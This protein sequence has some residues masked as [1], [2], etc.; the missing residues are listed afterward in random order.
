ML[1]W[2]IQLR[3][4]YRLFI[5]I[6]GFHWNAMKCIYLL[7]HLWI[8]MLVWP[9]EKAKRKELRWT[10]PSK[11]EP[12]PITE[13]QGWRKRKSANDWT[14]HVLIIIFSPSSDLGAVHRFVHWSTATSTHLWCT[15]YQHY[16]HLYTLH[17]GRTGAIK[18]RHSYRK[19]STPSVANSWAHGRVQSNI[20]QK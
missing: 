4:R 20:H 3:L 17:N 5:D 18:L 1:S 8:S 14:Q 19:A 10:G 9:I 15:V 7:W 2:K 6:Y 12:K 13:W 16:A 11:S